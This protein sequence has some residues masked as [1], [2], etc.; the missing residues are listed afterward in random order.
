MEPFGLLISV[1][2]PDP[3][4]LLAFYRDTIGLPRCSDT[5][6]HLLITGPAIHLALVEGAA[7][8]SDEAPHRLTFFVTDLAAEQVRL[9]EEG[10]R[11]SRRMQLEPWGAVRSV[12]VDPDGNSFELIEYADA[13]A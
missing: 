9:D 8:R 13:V 1:S 11:C 4:R 7:G 3:A 12:F 5:C 6:D 10:V 2:S